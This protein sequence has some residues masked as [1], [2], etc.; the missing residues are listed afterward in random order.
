MWGVM[1]FAKYKVGMAAE[2]FYGIPRLI[3]GG[4][5][6]QNH[7]WEFRGARRVEKPETITEGIQYAIGIT[8][9][10][11]DFPDIGFF[12]TR[13]WSP[14]FAFND[15]S[16]HP[17]YYSLLP[18]E[19][20]TAL[21]EMLN[22]VPKMSIPKFDSPIEEKFWWAWQ[23][24]AGWM[25]PLAYQHPVLDG[26]YRLDFAFPGRKIA[27]ELDGYEWHSSRTQFTKDRQRQRELEADGWR[28]IRFSGQEI[29][30]DADECFTQAMYLT[31]KIIS[32][33]TKG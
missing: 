25:L 30:K 27:I 19:V 4:D 8:E 32:G 28:F 17:S 10:D 24:D 15:V 23:N 26:K 14:D 31:C 7:K 5:L 2:D 6:P 11:A 9:P 21:M 12:F 18:A 22:S 3:I 1:D 20:F 13:Y 16:F 33:E 29:V